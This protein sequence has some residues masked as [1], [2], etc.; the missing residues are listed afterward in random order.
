MI[1]FAKE[2]FEERGTREF[3]MLHNSHKMALGLESPR[4]FDSLEE[5][6]AT[7]KRYPC[8]DTITHRV[9]PNLVRV[10]WN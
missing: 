5:A 1:S 9:E 7:Q 3:W 8:L 4:I 10:R 2:C 6:K